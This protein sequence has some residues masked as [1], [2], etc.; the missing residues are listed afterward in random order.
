MASD[1]SNKKLSE[2]QINMLRKFISECDNPYTE[3]E[4]KNWVYDGDMDMKRANAYEAMQILKK[5]GLL[6]EQEDNH[7]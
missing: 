5:H 1:T 7:D 3:E 4:M 2:K 6:E